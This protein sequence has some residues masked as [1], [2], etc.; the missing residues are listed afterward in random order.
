M[1]LSPLACTLLLAACAGRSGTDATTTSDS[2]GVRIVTNDARRPAWTRETAWLVANTP[3]IQVG[4][5]RGGPESQFYHVQHSRRLAD[6]GIAV[7][8]TGFGDLRLFDKGGYYVGTLTL[9][10]DAAE[11]APPLRVYEPTPGDLLVVQGD[12]SLALFHGNDSRPARARLA[13]P[14]GGLEKLEPLGMFGDG[15]LL[16]KA[17]H[18]WDETKTGVGRR[19]ARLLRYGP[20]GKLLGAVGDVDDNAVLFAN[21]GAYIFGA[22]AFAA[23]GDS[24]IWYGDGEHG[25]VREIARDGRLLRI[26]RIDRPPRAVT[27]ADRTAYKSAATRQVRGTTREAT[28]PTTL[29]SSVFADTFP[30]FDQIVVDALGD[31]WLRNYQWF[32]LGSGKSWSVFDPTGRYLG[33]VVTPSI[34]EIHQIGADF[35]LGRM[36]DTAG[37]EAVFLYRLNKPGAGPP[38]SG[39]AGATG[40]PAGGADSAKAPA[41]P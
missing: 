19:R 12:Q 38:A 10:D 11:K 27:P 4:N 8:N 34:L 21:R 26:V 15:S 28:M 33:D 6:G 29:D 3:A 9:G 14:E 24:T 13:T 39:A 30:T 23:P 36:A 37:R 31:V 25:E 20:D 16:F 7:A 41:A 5:I 35:L 17:R 1:R 32:D 2:A 22:T 40:A 18:P